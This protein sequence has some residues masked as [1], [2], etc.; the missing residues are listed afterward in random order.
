[1]SQDDHQLLL[2][3]ETATARLLHVQR[4]LRR[5]VILL[6]RTRTVAVSPGLLRIRL[7]PN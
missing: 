7:R 1:M 2:E 4:V 6:R 5:E 3:D